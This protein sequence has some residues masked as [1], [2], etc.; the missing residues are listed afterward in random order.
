MGSSEA[1]V[2][3]S[4]AG[5]VGLIAAANLIRHGIPVVVLERSEDVPRD[6]R[7]ST[8]HPPT[9]DML[10]EFGIADR[11][12]ERGLVCRNWQYRDRD[13]GVVATF[14][15]GVLSDDTAYP[16]RLQC[17]QW[18]MSD[19][20]RED[21]AGTGG[22]DMRYGH[23]VT[24]FTQDEDGVTVLFTDPA[25]E[26]GEVRGR[27]LIA[28]DG[29]HSPIRKQLGVKF[30]GQTIPEIFLSISTSFDFAAVIPDLAP[31]AYVSDPD[32]WQV[33]LRTPTLW[34]VLLPT[35]ARLSDDEIKNP[36][37]IERRLQA[38]QFNPD[39]YE[40]L[41]CTAYR[42]HERV[43]EA[44]VHGRVFLAGDAAHLNNP[45]GGMGMNGGIHDALNLTNRLVEVLAGA[46]P[47]TLGR[48]E[49][50]RRKVALDTVQATTLRNRK[51]MSEKDPAARAA[52]HDE[53]R[54]IVADRAKHRAHL[55]KA[56]MIQSLRD[57]EAVA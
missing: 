55:L 45:L 48:Y 15:M 27:Y 4:G 39:R 47:E 37:T 18:K 49:R 11:L 6:L 28:A 41:H 26:P 46:A 34:R 7:A 54:G 35:D 31:I 36:D 13:T 51:M 12:V 44:Y 38:I 8:F 20:L 43:A 29:A 30:D 21:F 19:M 5:P 22:I 16:F 42:V 25:G 10:A 24:G 3:I 1:P 2:I 17:E 53:L 50:Q 56:S 9:L 32:E 23:S 57:L 52:Y 33:L 14:D 40:I